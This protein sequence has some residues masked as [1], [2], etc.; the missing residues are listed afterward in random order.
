MCGDNALHFPAVDPD[1]MGTVVGYL[2]C[3]EREQWSFDLRGKGVEEF[4]APV[5]PIF[6]VRLY[7]LALSLA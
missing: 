2:E 6:Y 3:D 1:V 5:G 7:K 4:T